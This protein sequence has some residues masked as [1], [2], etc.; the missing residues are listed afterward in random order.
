[1][2][3]AD[4]RILKREPDSPNSPFRWIKVMVLIDNPMPEHDHRA[5]AH[6][7]NLPLFFLQIR[8]SQPEL[9]RDRKID[10]SRSVKKLSLYSAKLS[11]RWSSRRK[12]RFASCVRDCP[13]RRLLY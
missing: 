8:L 3:S 7:Q 9:I 10:R 13:E 2:N 11:F 12:P 1:M 5:A 4:F 6:I